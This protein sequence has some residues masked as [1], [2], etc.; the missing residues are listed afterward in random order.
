MKGPTLLSKK[1]TGFHFNIGDH[2][3]IIALVVFWAA[4]IITNPAF[5]SF[6]MY[7][8]IVKQGSIFA[9][10]GIGMTFA[11]ASGVF[12]L[13]IASQ[14]AL[15]SVVFTTLIPLI[16]PET[17]GLGIIITCLI[18]IAMGLIMGLINGLLVARLRIPAFIATLGMQLIYRGLAQFVNDAPVPF[19]TLG[20]D[21]QILTWGTGDPMV[22]SIGDFNI[23]YG[24]GFSQTRI[25]ELPLYF[26]LMV[27]VAVVGTIVMR[28]TRIGRYVLAIGNSKDAA[29]IA[30]INIQHT[31]T[32][33]FVMVGLFTSLAAIMM[34]SH[35]GSSNY[36][37]PAGT[38]FTVISAVVLGGTA[39]VGG[40]GS[41]FNTVIAS[42]FIA[43]IPQALTTFGIDNNTHDIFN[44]AI[45]VL[46]FSINTIRTYMDD[47]LVKFR[48]RRDL[49]KSS[50]L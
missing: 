46:A 18:V 13:S 19:A 8:S 1:N 38:E 48:A 15:S 37:V 25:F 17:P 27:L 5:R 45:L 23:F 33:T 16:T 26:Y 42:M 34:M 28:K 50:N 40:K 9:V 32:V 35:L 47:A 30:G 11:I 31:Q 29:Q 12:D 10:A 39:I 7:S 49:K 24:S 14:I 21:Y 44:G 3:I 22:W 4:L 43:T 6:S 20:D 41:I 36:G 2:T